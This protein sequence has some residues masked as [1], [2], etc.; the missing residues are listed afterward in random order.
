MRAT[1]PARHLP[2]KRYNKGLRLSAEAQNRFLSQGQSST[3][4]GVLGLTPPNCR[5]ALPARGKCSEDFDECRCCRSRIPKAPERGRAA[6]VMGQ[7][8][9][10]RLLTAR[11]P[12]RQLA[13][14]PR[15][16]LCSR[17][18]MHSNKAATSRERSQAAGGKNTKVRTSMLSRGGAP[19]VSGL[20]KDVWNDSRAR[21]SLALS[22][23]RMNNTSSGCM[24]EK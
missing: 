23:T 19:G 4:G 21:P 5:T 20:S 3:P 16:R 9:A 2:C 12:E 7:D 15:P 17:A 8:T 10:A 13:D 1:T 18:R 11:E 6:G 22:C 24:S 14:L